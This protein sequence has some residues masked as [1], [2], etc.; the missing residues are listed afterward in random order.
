M[1]KLREIRIKKGLF[2]RD[3]AK[4]LGVN[5]TAVSKYE[6]EQ[7]MLNQ[8]QIVTLALALEVTPDELLGFKE[9]Y[10]KYTKYLEQLA[11]DNDKN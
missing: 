7:R 3:I 4:F 10:E 6:L 2:Q 8:D 5:Q 1:L 9:A 11:K